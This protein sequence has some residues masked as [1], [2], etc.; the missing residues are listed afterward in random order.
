MSE[1]ENRVWAQVPDGTREALAGMSG[2]DLRSLLLSVAR[3][4]AAA[5]RPADLMRR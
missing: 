5:V 1:A 2:T 3:T 4:R